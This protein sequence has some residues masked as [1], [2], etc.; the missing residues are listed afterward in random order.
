M[1]GA[2]GPRVTASMVRALIDLARDKDY[3]D[4]VLGFRAPVAGEEPFAFEHNGQPVSVVPC[5]STLAAHA[6][7]LDQPANGWLVLVTDRT[8]DDLGAGLLAHV[9]G[10]RFRHPDAW[11]A[12]QQRF[13]AHA[14]DAQLTAP[15]THREIAAGLL[16][17][18]PHQGWP[19]APAGVL[20]R[21][22]ALGSVARALLDL[23]TGPVD[24]LALVDWSTHPQIP[25]R[26]ADLRARA[27]DALADAVVSWLSGGAGIGRSL[28]VRLLATGNLEQLVPLGLVLDSLQRQPGHESDLA[29]ARLAHH[30]GDVPV[31]A[32]N[33]V[34]SASVVLLADMLEDPIR[35]QRAQRL[36]SLAD[37]LVKEAQAESLSEV[38]DVLRSGLTRRS[39]RLA[40][41]LDRQHPADQA[42]IEAAWAS[43]RDHRLSRADASFP[44][45]E[46]AVRLCRWLATDDPTVSRGNFEQLTHRQLEVDA[47]VD[48][49]VND[50]A[51]GVEDHRMAS[52]LERV[53]QRVREVR[54]AHD[55]E[56]ATALAR[57][58]GSYGDVVPL[59]TLVADVVVPLAAASPTLLL[60]LD[61]LSTGVATELISSIT[62][63]PDVAMA[64]ALLPERDRRAAGLAVLPSVTEFSRTSL[65]TG[66]LTGG[67][68]Q[69]ELEGFEK[70]TRAHKLSGARLFH[71]RSLDTTRLGY[72]V[73]D[74]VRAA[75]DDPTISLVA[76][77]L[78]TIDDALDRSDPSGTAWT[79]DAIKHLI[80][81]LQRARD[82]GRTVVIT[83]DHGHIVERREGVMRSYAGGANTRFRAP[84]GTLAAD[85]VVVSGPR[86]LTPGNT[87]VLAVSERLR[88][89]PLK[90]GYHGGAAP[91]EVV[92]PIVILVPAGSDQLRLAPPQEP[93]WW[94]DPLPFVG[95]P[96]PV[97]EAPQPSLFHEPPAPPPVRPV[98]SRV[99][100]TTTYQQQRRLAGRVSIDDAAMVALL[101]ALASA[102]GQRIT[103]TQAA[104]ALGVAESRVSMAL[105]QVGKLLNVEGYPVVAI[106]PG[107]QNVILD[108]AL[109]TEQ[110]GV[111]P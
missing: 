54:D 103:A 20:T 111:K 78:N 34:A 22:H 97:P 82:A 83:S 47:W 85:E 23:P 100:A 58:S 16:E 98:G 52:G 36:L 75:I 67:Q 109:L 65:L 17:V 61:G 84:D 99:T 12:V 88:Y 80:P 46:A 10:Q 44:A 77:V 18:T 51:A 2:K 11:Q 64:E 37:G 35:R 104:M 66:R 26:L 21:D 28:V 1:S 30:W 19:P 53:L 59:E 68:Q 73:A 38:S 33:A 76:C 7:V 105:G 48:A 49:A 71:K 70:L 69:T 14:L 8:D 93:I 94:S 40:G 56:F 24:L 91:A 86:V 31:A 15:A 9:I 45:V 41:L 27:G 79:A 50:A 4:G 25:T 102:P 6:A 95:E 29:R 108:Q 81:L 89:G 72:S 110:F 60:V 107:T 39:L 62:S 90:A 5:V 55:V 57:H 92:V 96:P 3:H 43:F 42:E 101:D 106:D 13:G 32:L 63:R 87:A 74:D